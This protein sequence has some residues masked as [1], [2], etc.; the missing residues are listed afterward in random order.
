MFAQLVVNKRFV[1][2]G[3]ASEPM[4]DA[5]AERVIAH[6]DL[7]AFFA[8]VEQRDRPRLRGQPVV[9]GGRPN[10][11]GV[12]A[13]ASYEARARGIYVPMPLTRAYRVCPQAH[14]VPGRYDAYEQASGQV[15]EICRRYSPNVLPA[16]I[17]EGYL[18]WTQSQWVGRMR[19][20]VATRHWPIDLAES[21]RAAVAGET[22]L[23]VSIGIGRNRLIAKIASK[24]CKPRGVCHVAAG[25]EAA[26]LSP[27][28]LAVVPG[29]GPRAAAMLDG[30][31]LNRIGQ[32]RELSDA[33]LTER[34]GA[35][36]AIRLRRMA[37][38]LGGNRT[39]VDVLPTEH[40]P[41]SISNERTF[42]TDCHDPQRI[43]R[44]L[45][46]LI[47]KAAWR[48]RRAELKSATVTIKYR[49]GDFHTIT[50]S[51]TL[52]CWTDCHQ[53]INAAAGELL[54]P[55]VGRRGGCRL[56]GVQLTNLRSM[57]E[58]QLTLYEEGEHQARRRV[59]RALDLIR[60]RCG[61][62]GVTTAAA[63]G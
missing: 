26:L 11:R 19:R 25:F 53:D 4:A 21:L 61:Y 45:Y 54:A 1:S 13:S 20:R 52:S 5:A 3:N 47:E 27:L 57:S 7:D 44:T 14:F 50:R 58:R 37:E 2:N 63:L 62:H 24:Y 17:D 6:V 34:V 55:L 59:D 31:G 23:S 60:R 39:D 46:R 43:R 10:Q 41:K 38:G 49:R 28:P 48:L 32:V 12:V 40:H 29:I 9:V 56:I 33:A 18:D 8:S 42:A 35:A 51:A 30:V 36:W 15:F 22:G 16:S